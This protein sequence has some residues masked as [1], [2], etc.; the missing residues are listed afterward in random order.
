MLKRALVFGG[1]QQKFVDR[2]GVLFQ[3]PTA[4]WN[5]GAMEESSEA[6]HLFS[7]LRKFWGLSPLYQ[8]YVRLHK[9]PK[10]IFSTTQPPLV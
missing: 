5:R 4:S 8:A 6:Q 2:T 3:L 1:G 10:N 7:I 9:L